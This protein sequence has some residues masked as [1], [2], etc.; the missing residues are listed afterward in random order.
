MGWRPDIRGE[1]EMNINI[2]KIS[3]LTHTS[4]TDQV[5]VYTDMPS[6]FP[7]EV[8]DQN[9]MLKFD[10]QNGKGIEY[11]KKNF[12]RVIIETID[13]RNGKKELIQE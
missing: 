2:T 7:I 10:V 9:L 11:V 1:A 6:P 8:S 13:Y 5:F 4:G 3:I 12:S